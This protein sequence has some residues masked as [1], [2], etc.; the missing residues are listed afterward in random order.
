MIHSNE[1]FS[2][3]SPKPTFFPFASILYVRVLKLYS[4]GRDTLMLMPFFFSL[5]PSFKN[6]KKK[7]KNWTREPLTICHLQSAIFESGRLTAPAFIS[8]PFGSINKEDNQHRW[9]EFFFVLT[10]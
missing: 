1:V 2:Y 3:S 7:K 6:K 10:L 9:C 8:N 5:L 4:S